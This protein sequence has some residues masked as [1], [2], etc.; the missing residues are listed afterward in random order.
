MIRRHFVMEKDP[1]TVP[2]PS[3]TPLKTV[4]DRLNTPQDSSKIAPTPPQMTQDNPKTVPRHPKTPKDRLK[5][6][7]DRPKT[8]PRRSKTATRATQDR[9]RLPQERPRS[10]LLYFLE[11][12]QPPRG[13]KINLS[14]QERKAR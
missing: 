2:K 11:R 5:T 1:K 7:Q 6:A 10:I 12:I 8:A 14:E 3:Q 4:L 13:S 9:P